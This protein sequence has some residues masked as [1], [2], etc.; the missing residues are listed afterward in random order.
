MG[1]V[2]WVAKQNSFAEQLNDTGVETT[3]SVTAVVQSSDETAQITVP[4]D[5]LDDLKLWLPQQPLRSMLGRIGPQPYSGVEDA[6][7]LVVTQSD[8]Q[9]AH[10][11]PL[12]TPFTAESSQLF[13]L[14][15]RAI[16]MPIAKRK[17]CVLRGPGSSAASSHSVEGNGLFE[18]QLHVQ[19]RAVL[20]LVNRWDALDGLAT[21]Q[22]HVRL[23]HSAL[24]LWRIPHPD[25]LIQRT[26][27][28]RQ[29]WLSLQ[30]LQSAL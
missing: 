20:L 4:P 25:L 30:A 21:D 17:L 3:T 22:H 7:L 11:E 19:T 15:M 2:P 8:E 28:K 16:A 24:P 6:P 14:M 12:R 27:L 23:D 26:A 5:S 29:A 13:E 18:Q 10:D 1:I 9:D